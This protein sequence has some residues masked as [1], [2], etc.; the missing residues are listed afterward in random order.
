MIADADLSRRSFLCVMGGVGASFALGSFSTMGCARA[1][2]N[3]TSAG[4]TPFVPNA[5]V[6]VDPDSAITVTIS[7]SDMGQGVRTSF[8]MLVAE[9]LDANW[10]TIKVTQAPGDGAKYGAMGTGGSS[11]I[12]SMHDQLRQIGAA[13]RLMLIS[14]A[15]QNWSVDPSTC[16]TD[17]GKVIHS[18][19]GRS[20]AY[21]ELTGIAST[22]SAPPSANVKIKDPKD[23]KIVGTPRDRVDN[24]DVVTGRAQYGI[25]VKVDGMKYAMLVRPPAFGATLSS[26]DDSVARQIPGVVDVFKVEDGVCVL[27]DNTWAAIKGRRALKLTWNPGPNADVTS[28]SI[29]QGLVEALIPHPEMAAGA[30]IV[31][32]TYD[33][34]YIAHATMEPMNAVADVRA[35]KCVVWTGSQG[36]DGIQGMAANQTKLSPENVTVNNMLLGGGFGRRGNGDFAAQAV[37]I[38]KHAKAPVKLTWMREDDMKNDFYRPM[39]HHSMRGAVDASGNPVG[40]SQQAISAGMGRRNGG[41][42]HDGGIP[43]DIPNAKILVGGAPSPVPNGA[44]RSVEHTQLDVVNEMFMDEMA[45]ACGQDPYRFR[46][47]HARDPRLKRVLDT[48]AEKSGW[49]KPVPAGTGRG[50]ACFQ[51][52]DSFIAHVVELSVAGNEIKLHHVWV[53]VDVGQAVNPRGIEAQAQGACSDALSLALLAEITIDKGG[54]VQSSWDDYHWMTMDRVPPTEVTLVNGGTNFGGMGE[55]GIPSVAPAV[56]NAIFAAT[57]KRVRKLPIRLD[58][59]A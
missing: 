10:K 14:A 27:A 44:W 43:Y 45:H 18:Q 3:S 4:G 46:A 54:V 58:E 48:V 25:D 19:S 59:L 22:L 7:K 30:K 31:E 28:A 55:V 13:A 5:F 9:E 16:T 29:R 40:W 49:D 38:S 56:A 32:A 26:V 24:L 53:A 39:S 41:Q 37:E 35:D 36:P 33:V 47:K 15:A 21:G 6:K 2:A 12:R 23:F 20:A 51:G 42:F 17:N 11:S 50:I 8:A 34:P 57:G 52:Y 1:A